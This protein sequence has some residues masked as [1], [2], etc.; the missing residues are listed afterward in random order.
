MRLDAITKLHKSDQV[1]QLMDQGDQKGIFI[2]VAIDA[3]PVIRRLGSMPVI[4]QDTLPLPGDRK[5]YLIVI[6]I[7][8]YQGRSLFRDKLTEIFE[9]GFFLR[10]FSVAS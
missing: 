3:D 1:G 5:M 2:Q 10:H 6:E 7:I 4:P 8:Q 9:R